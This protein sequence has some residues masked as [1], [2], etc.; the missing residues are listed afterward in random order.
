M[1]MTD[2]SRLFQWV[3]R[4]NALLILI[5]GVG[6]LLVLAYS[7]VALW[8]AITGEKQCPGMVNLD[9]SATYKQQWQYST[10]IGLDGVDH[11]MVTLKSGQRF[12]QENYSKYTESV[13]NL[14]FINTQTNENHWLL[15][16]NDRLILEHIALS[17]LPFNTPERYVRVIVFT[18]VEQ[19][20]NDDKR[21]TS[22][23]KITIMISQPDGRRLTTVVDGVES[24]TDM[25]L[26]DRRNL[27][28]FYQKDQVGYSLIISLSSMMPVSEKM[29][30]LP[31]STP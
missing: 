9:D 26:I 27:L 19:D 28:L 5:I 12:A 4:L 30:I 6:S 24:V 1:D 17:E 29:V 14:L 22:E 11:V 21:L 8:G 18:V 16:D 25:R 15:P 7:Y 3:W 13:R 23:D 2:K 10:V 20:S 31:E